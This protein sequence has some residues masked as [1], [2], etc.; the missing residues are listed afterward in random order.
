VKLQFP[1]D[2][3][4]QPIEPTIV[5]AENYTG[6]MYSERVDTVQR[7]TQAYERIQRAALDEVSSRTLLR[8]IARE[9]QNER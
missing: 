5:Y 3:R 7:Y 1:T 6:D 4:G 9:Y 8:K 2:R